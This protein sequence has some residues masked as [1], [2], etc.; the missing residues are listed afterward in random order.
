[1]CLKSYILRI[2]KD[3]D[4]VRY[5]QFR[6]GQDVATLKLKTQREWALNREVRQ[7]GF[8][9]PWEDRMALTVSIETDVD[10]YSYS[11]ISFYYL[12]VC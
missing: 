7:P 11:H 1:M 5:F 12:T 10:F 6:Q 2:A 9:K 3:T 4:S 8:A